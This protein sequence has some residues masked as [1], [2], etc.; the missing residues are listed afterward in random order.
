MAGERA[1]R[2]GGIK[3]P[4]EPP[5]RQVDRGGRAAGAGD[6]ALHAVVRQAA[7]AASPAGAAAASSR[8]WWA[9]DVSGLLGS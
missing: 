3:V 2:A 4:P 5:A 1:E 6:A 7:A 8:R 9:A